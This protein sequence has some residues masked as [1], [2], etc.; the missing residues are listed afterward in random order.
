MSSF[1]AKA[2]RYSNA[3]RLDAPPH[4][5]FSPLNFLGYQPLRYIFEQFKY[6]LRYRWKTA[7]P[8]VSSTVQKDGIAT[9]NNFLTDSLFAEL[10]K[11]ALSIIERE[12]LSASQLIS[13]SDDIA[14]RVVF[15][16]S[17][18]QSCR[19]LIDLDAWFVWDNIQR[20]Q[21]ISFAEDIYRSKYLGSSHL[22]VEL[23]MISVQPGGSDHFDHNTM[24]HVDR[25]F[26]CAKM[27]LFLNDH[28]KANGTY[29]YTSPRN[30]SV[31]TRIWYEYC[32][33]CRTYLRYLRFFD[34]QKSVSYWLRKPQVTARE[35]A[36]LNIRPNPIEEPSNT[37]V[38]SNNISFHR[39]GIIQPGNTRLQINLDFYN[40]HRN[41]AMSF[42]RYFFAFLA[43]LHR[44]YANLTLKACLLLGMKNNQS[45]QLASGCR[46]F[47]LINEYDSRFNSMVLSGEDFAGVEFKLFCEAAKQSSL[48]FDVGANFGCFTFGS[49]P[50]PPNVE[51][52][53]F[54]PNVK[55]NK[56]IRKTI[57]TNKHLTQQVSVYDYAISDFCG[58]TTFY[59]NSNW[60]GSS[61][62]DS[63]IIN[64]QSGQVAYDVQTLTLDQWSVNHGIDLRNKALTIKIDV[65]GHDLSALYGARQILEK[66][67]HYLIIIELDYKQFESLHHPKVE[68]L[69]E[70]F[71][72]SDFKYIISSDSA[73]AVSSF[74]LLLHALC[75]R[76]PR[77]LDLV[78]ASKFFA[79]S[80]H[81][82]LI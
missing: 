33:S 38:I 79:T 16:S 71:I 2:R 23:E 61:S 43:L 25:H 74:D 14:T 49:L 39:R 50:L 32:L 35:L 53:C 5:R 24:W 30:F 3:H 68:F 73:A 37:L 75:K 44:Q 76:S 11:S 60:S 78:L 67:N 42:V 59:V 54:E 21:L 82:S 31:L 77:H 47:S 62:L 17:Y 63:K 81:K 1:L 57:S 10:Q 46:V 72:E 8:L 40:C 4:I 15:D 52:F 51:A 20:D 64:V 55:L 26:N 9:I 65:E 34:V 45:I 56:S 27:F 19:G 22:K 6:S 12:K 28:T 48:I 70:L 66:C 41:I 80:I 7:N 36:L 18:L 58:P 13:F 69:R 29:E